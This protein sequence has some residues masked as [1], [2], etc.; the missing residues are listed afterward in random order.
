MQAT[1]VPP[2]LEAP[3]TTA[4]LPIGP[5]E[6]AIVGPAF[7]LA[8][9][10]FFM[11]LPLFA[12]VGA[13]V[14]LVGLAATCALARVGGRY[15]VEEYLL[16]RIGFSRRV[17]L[18]AKGGAGEAFAARRLERGPTPVPHPQAAWFTLPVDR[19]PENRVM[20]ANAVGLALLSVFISWLGSGG[21]EGLMQ[22]RASVLLF[23]R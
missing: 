17:R 14:A 22:V 19:V 18:R 6:L 5:R 9:S 2:K 8:I 16:C 12:R 10:L 21:L 7:A 3:R 20:L 23:L 4:G 13:A 1:H 11:G 15:T